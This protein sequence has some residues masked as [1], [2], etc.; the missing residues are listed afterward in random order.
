VVLHAAVPAHGSHSRAE[1]GQGQ[2]EPSS[3][4]AVSGWNGFDPLLRRRAEADCRRLAA[5]TPKMNP[6]GAGFPRIGSPGLLRG[7]VFDGLCEIVGTKE[8]AKLPVRQHPVFHL[9]PRGMADYCAGS[10]ASRLILCSNGVRGQHDPNGENQ[11]NAARGKSRN[12]HFRSPEHRVSGGRKPALRARRINSPSSP[13]PSECRTGFESN[14][15]P[16]MSESGECFHERPGER[17]TGQ[18]PR[19]YRHYPPQDTVARL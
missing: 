1:P 15:R 12:R 19:V 18:Y 7:E 9:R 17:T 16:P 6:P 13:Q 8:N 5:V 2:P 3:V 11:T 4:P 14:Y 10:F